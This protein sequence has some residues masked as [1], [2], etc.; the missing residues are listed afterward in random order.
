MNA[1]RFLQLLILSC[2]LFQLAPQSQALDIAELKPEELTTRLTVGYAVRAIDINADKRLDIAIVDSKRILWLENPSWTEHVVYETAQAKFDNVCFAPWDINGDGRVDLALGADWQ[3]GNSNSGGTIGWLE[4]TVDGPWLY[5]SIAQEPTTHRM[6]WLDIFGNGK[7]NLIVAPL[8]GRGSREPGFDQVGIRLLAFE[9][10]VKPAAEIWSRRVLTDQL[11]VMHN[12]DVTD[13]DDDGRSDLI[14]ASYE[15]VNWLRFDSQGNAGIKRL[16]SGQ[17]EPAPKQGCSEIRLGIL[18]NNKYIATIEPWHGDKVVVYAQPSDWA[19][20]ET[21]WP[22]L[23]LDTELA[24]G[25]AIACANL[26]NDPDQE[27]IVGIRDN[28]SENHR[29][30]VRIYD[31]VDVSS[32]KWNRQIVDPGGVAV[33]DLVAADLDNDGDNDIIAVGRAT[34]NVKIYWNG[35]RRP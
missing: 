24:W 5:H 2:N 11:H 8:K 3:F 27:L 9:P 6:V 22:R 4:H 26:D 35:M 23:V 13:L 32:G 30:G 10:G 21:L 33:E 12:L 20:R 29:C 19:T 25:H 34:H 31:P 28:K 16:G 14:T 15:G 7:L 17:E 1:Q 18:T